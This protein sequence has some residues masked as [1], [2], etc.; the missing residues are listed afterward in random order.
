[1]NPRQFLATLSLLLATPLVLAASDGEA[2]L[3]VDADRWEADQTREISVFQGNVVMR[4]GGIL[5]K[6]DEARIK[7]IEG[8]VQFGTIIGN[9]AI[10]EQVPETGAVVSGHADRIEYD[11]QNELVILTGSARVSQGDDEFSGETI[12]Y[13]LRQEKVLATGAE[14]TP[15]RVRIIFTPRKKTPP[16][17]EDETGNGNAADKP[18]GSA[19]EDDSENR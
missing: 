7:A 13:D 2:P 3:Q 1:M 17:G 19:T 4:K 15:Q 6:A 11:A 14:K 10:F 8:R 12:R 16:A 18:A 9:P 5:I